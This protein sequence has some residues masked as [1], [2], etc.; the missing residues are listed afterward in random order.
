M[1]DGRVVIPY[2]DNT[3]ILSFRRIFTNVFWA[4]V[5]L[6]SLS[7]HYLIRVS[8]GGKRVESAQLMCNREAIL[9]AARAVDDQVEKKKEGH[10]TKLSFEAASEGSV[11]RLFRAALV[12]EARESGAIVW[13]D[14][15]AR[16]NNQAQAQQDYRAR[17]EKRLMELK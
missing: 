8:E 2:V 12:A 6:P 5:E 15:F 4:Q 3:G 14:G 1:P 16:E 10:C 11:L 7:G 9:Q 13:A 17:M